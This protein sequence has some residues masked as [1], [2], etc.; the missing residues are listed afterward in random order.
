[1]SRCC[2]LLVYQKDDRPKFVGRYL[3]GDLIGEGSYSKVKEVID[4]ETLERRAVK[5]MKRQRLRKIPNGE[6]NVKRETRLMQRLNHKNVIKLIDIIYNE[7]KQK[8]YLI[9]EYCVTVLQELFDRAPDNKLPVSQAHHYFVQLI[10]GL[11]YLHSL[12]IIHKD[13]KPSNLLI[14]NADMIKITDL[15]VSEQL[16]MFEREDWCSMSQGSPAFQ[17]PELAEGVDKFNGYKIDIW[18]SGVTL[19]SITTGKYPFEGEN[20]YRLFE[21]ISKGIFTMPEWL[22]PALQNLLYGML[23]KDPDQRFDIIQVRSHDWFRRKHPPIEEHIPLICEQQQQE[24]VISDSEHNVHDHTH[25]QYHPQ[26]GY[27]N[28][29]YQPNLDQDDCTNFTDSRELLHHGQPDDEG[30]RHES[31]RSANALAAGEV[32][33]SKQ[34]GYYRAKEHSNCNTLSSTVKQQCLLL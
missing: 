27:Y 20:I 24:Q 25:H 11:G 23:T 33:C 8:L 13:I 6:E 30:R 17:A 18:S 3:I 7:E 34:H 2:D 21:K 9:M 19:Y 22:D 1:M 12:G 28:N 32:I 5:I 29:D 16:D 15:G 14:N 4:S 31:D 26:I 10:D